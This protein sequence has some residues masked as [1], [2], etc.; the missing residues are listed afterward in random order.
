MPA[1]CNLQHIEHIDVNLTVTGDNGRGEHP[2]AGDLQIALASPLGKVSTLLP[3]HPCT[4]KDKDGELKILACQGLQDFTFGVRRH[5]E[6]PVAAGAN[7][8]WILLVADRVQSGTG[9]LK[10]WSITFYGR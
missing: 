3:P 1:N 2:N 9:Q 6:E 10:N 8:N 4:K 7:R 5:L